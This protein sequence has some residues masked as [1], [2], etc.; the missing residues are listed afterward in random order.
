MLPC[1]YICLFIS[2]FNDDLP[3]VRN[4]NFEFTCSIDWLQLSRV[5]PEDGDRIQPPKRCVLKYKQGGVFR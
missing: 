5:L 2:L 3:T 4:Y 1:H